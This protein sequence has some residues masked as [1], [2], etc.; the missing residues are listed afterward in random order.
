[1]LKLIAAYITVVDIPDAGADGS[2]KPLQQHNI[3]S[4]YIVEWS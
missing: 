3:K 4:E 1:M 2:V